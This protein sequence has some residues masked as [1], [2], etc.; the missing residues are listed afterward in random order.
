MYVV[1]ILCFLSPE[2]EEGELEEEGAWPPADY[3]SIVS[4]CEFVFTR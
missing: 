4:T 1:A 2:E 3:L